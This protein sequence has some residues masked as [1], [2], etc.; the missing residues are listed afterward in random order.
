MGFL[1]TSH[2]QLRNSSPGFPD[3]HNIKTPIIMALDFN[4]ARAIIEEA[5]QRGLIRPPGAPE[6]TPKPAAEAQSDLSKKE[7]LPEWL[8]KEIPNQPQ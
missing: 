8:K 4:E 3:Q 6:P 1:G 2:T 7:A 5:K